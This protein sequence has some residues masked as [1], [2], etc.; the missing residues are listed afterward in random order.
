MHEFESML[1][2]PGAKEWAAKTGEQLGNTLAS[3]GH[4]IKGLIDWWQNLDGSTQKTLGGIVKWL[5]ITLV[6]MGTVLT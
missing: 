6:T 1:K 3:I 5:G 2:S 4:G